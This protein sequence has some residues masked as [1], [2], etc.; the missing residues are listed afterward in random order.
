M[1]KQNKNFVIIPG[2]L[3]AVFIG[4]FVFTAT[5]VNFQFSQKYAEMRKQL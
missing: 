4:L 3:Q 5:G 1:G 2:A